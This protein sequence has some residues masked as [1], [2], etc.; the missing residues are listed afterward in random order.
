MGAY[1]KVQNLY[2]KDILKDI[3]LEIEQSS[4]CALMGKNG[5]GKTILLKSIFGLLDI[6]G[7]ISIK[8]VVVSEE[9][10]KTIKSKLG[11]YLGIDNLENSTVF[12]NIIEPLKNLDYD[13]LKAKNKVYEISKKLDIENLLYKE[14]D[15]LSYAEKKIVSFATSV[16]HDPKILLLD[17]IFD[18]LDS[19][20]KLKVVSYLNYLKKSKKSIIIFTT[21]DSEDLKYAENLL[22]MKNG[23]IIVNDKIDNLTQN[24]SKFA[25]NDIKLPFL[26]DLSYKLKSYELIDKLIDN[27]EEMVDEVWQ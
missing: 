23:K 18:C 27:E 12:S 2:Y 25:K 6:V 1:L 4:I 9:T 13:E 10:V 3:D 21:N 11:I 26:I 15:Q 22:I 19:N 14:T 7:I 24:E 16:V 5:S 20:Y 17:N 8:D